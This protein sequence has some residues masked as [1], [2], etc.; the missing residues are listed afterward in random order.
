LRTRVTLF[1]AF[2]AL[3]AGVVLIGVTYGLTRNN[4]LDEDRNAA[5]QQA[6][7]NADLVREQLT[8]DPAGI[9]VFFDDELR[10]VNDGFAVLSSAD[11]T[12]PRAS[13]S[14]LHPITDFPERL[15]DSILAG[16]SALQ[17]ATIDGS[18]YVTVGVYIA[19]YDSG[20]FE[21]FPLA[22]TQST[23]TAILTALLLGALGTVVLATLFGLATSRRLLRP[24][25][26]VADA[27][28]DIASGGLDT[29][30]A[31]E[32]DPDLDRLAGSFNDMADAVQA[33]IEREAR[34]AS[35]VSHEL[36][37]PITAL[38]AA[39]EVLDG[40]RDDIPER[41]QQALDVVVDQVRRFDSMVI[42]L[43][44]LAR[45]DAGATDLNIE[46]VSLVDLTRR[47]AARF[48]EPDVPIVAVNGSPSE[49]AIDKVRFER[50]LGNL[51][52]NARNHGG[53]AVRI[54][55]TAASPG[56][57]RLAVE[58]GG[59]GVAQGERERIFE[60][61]ARGSAARHRIGTGL[62]L[63]LVAEHAAAMGGT[64]W[65]Q[66][67][68][69]GGARFVVELPNGLRLQGPSDDRLTLEVAR[70]DRVRDHA[71]RGMRCAD[72]R[73]QFR[74]DPC[75][76]GSVRSR[77]H[78]DHHV[79]DHHH[80]HHASRHAR[81]DRDHDD[82]RAP[83]TRRVLLPDH[84]EPPPTD[85]RRPPSAVLCGADRRHPGGRSA[86]GRRVDVTDRAGPDREFERIAR[87][88]DRRS[89]REHVRR[90]PEY[91]AD[92]GDRPD[93]D[94]DDQQSAPRRAGELHHRRRS[95]LGEEG[96]QPPVRRRRA[97]VVRR[98]RHPAR[99]ASAVR[100]SDVRHRRT[101]RDVD[102]RVVRQ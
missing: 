15:V 60:R 17:N 33:R 50:I 30:L 63:A 18:D 74:R 71:H 95:H 31:T 72:R 93:R 34:F 45:L 7:A 11:P 90:N 83:R 5:Q 89:R 35:D 86:T 10:T 1:F 13:T 69:G 20:Y 81:H 21:A 41:T 82:R 80:D 46:S 44:E 16:T 22:E 85:R 26:Q 8:L 56:R 100:R 92:R 2:I 3:L 57:F 32:S 76:G 67:R 23:L 55:L 37:S 51:L 68:V 73:R 94:D 54:E 64:T 77:R 101:H 66:D 28:A 88:V 58:D 97:L 102:P 53:G 29:R 14:V 38:T 59:P 19:E 25:S 36:R 61:F 65:V 84:Q 39:V 98:L 62:G 75:G 52:E 49:V 27:A 24:L 78:L 99:H 48:G 43:L 87:R 96:Q 79:D 40:R 4:L 6:L 12:A 91:A 70:S 47:V 42:D 9:G